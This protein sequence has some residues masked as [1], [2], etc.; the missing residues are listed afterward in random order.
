MLKVFW[1]RKD[2]RLED[3]AGLREFI[4]SVT[5]KDEILFL[6]I[7]NKN[8]YHYYGEKRINFL[9]ESLNELK[10]DLRE[11]GFD[12][13][14]TEGKSPEVFKKLK[15]E[16]PAIE[17]F[18]NEQVEPYS[19]ERDKEVKE[20]IPSFQL[21]IDNTIFPL[22]KIRTDEGNF[23][24]VFTPFKKK[25]LLLLK[26]ECAKQNCSL[27]KLEN[28]KQFKSSSLKEFSIP[29]TKDEIFKGG[30]KEAVRLLNIF[31]KEKMTA[32]KEQRDFPGEYGTSLLSPHIHFGAI[33]FREVFRA[34]QHKADKEAKSEIEKINID[35]WI[36]ELIWREFYYNITFHKPHIITKSFK[37]EFDKLKWEWNDE[38][39]K[40]WCE[41]KTGYPIVDAG[42][43]QLNETGWMHNRLRMITAMFL[44]KDLFMDW[45][46]GEKYFAEK[47]ID[48]DFSSN[49]GGWQWS[50]STGCDAQPYFRIFNPVLQSKKFDTD[51]SYI[52][53][54]VPELKDV[55]A[56][57]IH[58]PWEFETE[59]KEKYNITLGKNYPFP[60]V[61][62][63]EIKDRVISEFK[64]IQQKKFE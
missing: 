58:E 56:K 18:A 13:L 53:K 63:F 28:T 31:C 47:L 61:N 9:Y 64:R 57:Y 6:Y 60:V 7:K 33:G 59:L 1:F 45:R 3:N 19:I 36:S 43:R 52:K 30:R 2:L 41:G 25:F 38:L 42:M 17:V 20:I 54:Y 21:F 4:N 32:Y 51:G 12:L 55:D 40:K 49:N 48:L 22:G 50:A 35:S 24:S 62:H 26:G 10:N 46:L 8:K 27:D 37:P 14:I 11:K 39:F 15:K 16:N 44:T 29:E 34:A 23:Y 5:D